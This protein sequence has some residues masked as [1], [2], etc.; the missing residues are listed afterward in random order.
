LDSKQLSLKL[1]NQIIYGVED[2]FVIEPII[3]RKKCTIINI[4]YDSPYILFIGK[5][6]FSEHIYYSDKLQY[7]YQFFLIIGT[8]NIIRY[9]HFVNLILN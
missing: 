6:N 9:Y 7:N 5:F 3:N 1:L 8:L 2:L 4:E